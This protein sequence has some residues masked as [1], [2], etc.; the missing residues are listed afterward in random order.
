M[1]VF[2]SLLVLSVILVLSAGV[3]SA[4][5]T[6]ITFALGQPNSMEAKVLD[7]VSKDFT[8]ENP[9]IEVN[10]LAGPQSATD[11]L[12]LYLQFFEAQST[13]R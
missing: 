12:G 13:E 8:A 6:V 7:R 9:D 11:L 2:K 5:K 3:C 4:E 1:K 10:I